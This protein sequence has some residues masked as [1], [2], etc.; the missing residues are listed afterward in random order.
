MALLYGYWGITSIFLFWGALIRATRE[1]GG[2]S[3]Q[4][5]AFGVLEAGRGV[6]AAIVAYVAVAVLAWYLPENAALASDGERRAGLATVILLY[7]AAT[8]GAGI[9]T[10]LTIPAREQAPQ[11]RPNPL[12]GMSAVVRRPI[13][14][15]QAAV[16]ICAY[17]CYKGLD[18]YSLYAAQALGMDEVEA[19]RLSTHG[20]YLRPFAAIIAGLVADRVGAARSIAVTF[21]ILVV[22]YALLWLSAPEGDG[23]GLIYVNLVVSFFAA[24]ALRGVYF[25][26]LEESG[27]PTHVTGA[28]VGM[29][30]LVGFTPEVFFAPV[31][32]RI[33]D[34]DPGLVGHQ[35]YFLFLSVIAALG[36][37]VVAWLLWLKRAGSGSLWPRTL[38]EPVGT[39]GSASAEDRA[40][41]A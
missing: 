40:E 19:A 26:L 4:G 8:L 7:S 39:G 27:T 5:T 34:A 13:V 1:W 6:V 35:S 36:A 14:W 10:W 31:A 28:T 38:R 33:L 37:L 32:G 3:S 17:C 2:P 11:E 16:I 41:N 9:L 12:A 23:L 21:V 29:V 30:S 24:F 15:A 18:N 20:A 25:A 22:S